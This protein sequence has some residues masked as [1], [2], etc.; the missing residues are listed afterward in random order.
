MNKSISDGGSFNTLMP[1]MHAILMIAKSREIGPMISTIID[2]MGESIK[3]YL[4][5]SEYGSSLQ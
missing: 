3:I 1:L 2:S 5:A 4:R